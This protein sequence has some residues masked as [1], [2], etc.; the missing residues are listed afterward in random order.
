MILCFARIVK[1]TLF[2]YLINRIT[3]HMY[4]VKQLL[5]NLHTLWPMFS[6]SDLAA[7]A[8]GSITSV[9]WLRFC[10]ICSWNPWWQNTFTKL[11]FPC[12]C[13]TALFGQI[14]S[15]ISVGHH[16]R[17]TWFWRVSRFLFSWAQRYAFFFF[18]QRTKGFESA[19]CNLIACRTG[20]IFS[21]FSGQWREEFEAASEE[22]EPRVRNARR[23]KGRLLRVLL[24]RK[25][26]GKKYSTCSVV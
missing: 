4:S 23:R 3:L 1:N 15:C 8:N 6:G 2:S 24:A 13:F 25:T 18:N 22:P 12:V 21:R 14:R 7:V 17:K 11:H 26:R 19:I 20:V 9:I 16:T 5:F 10:I